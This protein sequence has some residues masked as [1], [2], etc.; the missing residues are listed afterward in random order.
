VVSTDGTSIFRLLQIV[1]ADSTLPLSSEQYVT[2]VL[3]S[4]ADVALVQAA[5]QLGIEG[6][7]DAADLSLLAGLEGT[8]PVLSNYN[9]SDSTALAVVESTAIVEYAGKG[10]PEM[11]PGRTRADVLRPGRRTASTVIGATKA[12]TKLVLR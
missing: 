4:Y 3:T 2:S 9:A 10:Y 12:G 5:H 7:F 1:V 6:A 8:A 11:S